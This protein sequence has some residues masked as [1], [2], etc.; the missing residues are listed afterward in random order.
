MDNVTFNCSVDE[1]AVTDD[2][3]VVEVA[4]NNCWTEVYDDAGDV[5]DYEA[6]EYTAD[7]RPSFNSKALFTT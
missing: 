1:Y 4:A 2:V 7:A 6:K 5:D 3:I